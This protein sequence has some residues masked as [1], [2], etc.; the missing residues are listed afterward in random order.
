MIALMLGL[1]AGTASFA[2]TATDNTPDVVVT[3]TQEKLQLYVAP[4]S[5]RA[6]IK[7]HDKLGHLL[8]TT[9]TNI[10]NGFRQTFDLS[11]LESGTYRLSVEKA[12]Q[13]ID[14]TVVIGSVPAQKQ[15]SLGA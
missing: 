7:L 12:G 11:N 2:Q 15:I 9:T 14:K 3:S 6:T 10:T 4:Q 5:T 1:V 13:T 8:Y